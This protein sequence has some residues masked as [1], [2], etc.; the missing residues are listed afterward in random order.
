[1]SKVILT[2]EMINNAEPASILHYGVAQDS[3]DRLFL[4]GTGEM[5]P[6]ILFRGNIADW[7]IYAQNPHYINPKM[8]GNLDIDYWQIMNQGMWFPTKIAAV[9]DKVSCESSIKY[10][11]ECDDEV[12]AKY[13]Y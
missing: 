8:T 13:R 4:A 7:C 5:T 10:L 11:V 9:G 2:M 6:W 3:V 12:F 1:M